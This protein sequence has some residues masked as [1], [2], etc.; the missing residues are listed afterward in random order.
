MKE[1]IA[2]RQQ[3]E[4][5]EHDDQ[6][7]LE[8]QQRDVRAE[9]NRQRREEYEWEEIE[10]DLVDEITCPICKELMFPPRQVYQ[11]GEGHIL[12]QYC[13]GKDGP[14]VGELGDKHSR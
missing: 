4:R 5:E 2:L 3:R 14:K 9:R 8:K 7:W 11:C 1:N 12:C 6:E 10:A 13:V